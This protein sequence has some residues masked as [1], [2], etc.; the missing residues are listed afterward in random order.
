MSFLFL[1]LSSATHLFRGSYISISQVALSHLFL[2][3]GENTTCLKEKKIS[4]HWKAP[5]CSHTTVNRTFKKL[6]HSLSSKQKSQLWGFKQHF[7]CSFC[8]FIRHKCNGMW[9]ISWPLGQVT[10]TADCRHCFLINTNTTTVT[11]VVS[12]LLRH[13][14][15]KGLQLMEK[16]LPNNNYYQ[17]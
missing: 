14:S 2:T 4:Q 11:Y 5:S 10:V 16:R 1:A 3:D 15:T 17:K 12:C 6:R 9:K 13:T 8:K 7:S